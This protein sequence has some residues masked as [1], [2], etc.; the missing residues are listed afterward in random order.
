MEVVKKVKKEKTK[1]SVINIR[2]TEEFSTKWRKFAKMNNISQTE[3]I[4]KLLNNIMDNGV[5]DDKQS[6]H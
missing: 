4:M 3:T 2:V 6:N 1:A 5:S